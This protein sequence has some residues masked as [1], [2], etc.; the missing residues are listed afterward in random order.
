MRNKYPEM[1]TCLVCSTGH[2]MLE[3][4]RIF[5]EHSQKTINKVFNT[6]Y[7]LIL[8]LDDRPKLLK[9][10]KK[11]GISKELRKFVYRMV[12]QHKVSMIEFDR[13][14]DLIACENFFDW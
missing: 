10:L 3:D 1:K 5:Q 9:S 2:M 6:E 8:I 12:S 7:G 14:A 11:L 4:I 13:D